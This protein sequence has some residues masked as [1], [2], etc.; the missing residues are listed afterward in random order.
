MLK[1]LVDDSGSS[2]I[3]TS[4]RVA[5][6][7]GLITGY[8]RLEELSHLETPEDRAG[9]LDGLVLF[10]AIAK[11]DSREQRQAIELGLS[12]A[13]TSDPKLLGVFLNKAPRLAISGA[14]FE[15]C[16][17]KA[18]KIAA[19]AENP[20]LQALGLATAETI[21]L[22]QKQQPR[23]GSLKQQIIEMIEEKE[24]GQK[25]SADGNEAET[26]TLHS[27]NQGTHNRDE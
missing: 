6:Q 11:V 23:T 16:L 7:Y 14:G 2:E 21:E 22:R 26:P 1:A 13:E 19:R 25:V 27:E 3:M 10:I 18:R 9:V 5:R 12:F 8:E 4:I 15:A 17:E 24:R 20:E